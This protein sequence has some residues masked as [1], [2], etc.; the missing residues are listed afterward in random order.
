MIDFLMIATRTGKR[1]TIEIYP[2]FIIKK[3]KDLM[4]RGSDFYAVWMEE[5]GL[6]STDE[7]DALQMI[8]RALDIYAEEHKQVFNDSYHVL[9]MWDAESG[10]IDNWHKYCQRQMRDNYHTLDDTLIFANTPVKKESYASKRLPY[11]LEEGNIS[12]YDELMTTLYSPEERK[13]IEWAVGAIVNGDSRKIQ[14]FLVLYGPPGSGKSTVLNIVRNFS[15]GTGRC[16]TPKCWG[17]RPMRLRWRR[18][19]R[20]R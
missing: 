8:D 10:M 19:N 9:H 12:A 7:Q 3:S 1:G 17:H 14:K 4:I 16:S 18:S 20:T 15:T 11:L 5:R 2:K 13:K 6:W